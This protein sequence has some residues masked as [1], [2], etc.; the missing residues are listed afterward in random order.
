MAT[1]TVTKRTAALLA[2]VAVGLLLLGSGILKTGSILPPFEGL[3]AGV[4]SAWSSGNGLFSVA[5]K[6]PSPYT[7]ISQDIHNTILQNDGSSW[8]LLTVGPGQVRIETQEPSL[9]SDGLTQGKEVDYWVKNGTEYYEVKGQVNVYTVHVTVSA[10]ETGWLNN[11]YDFSGEQIWMQLLGYGW[12]QAYQVQE[13]SPIS[14]NPSTYGRAW[15][16]PLAVFIENYQ[17]NTYGSEHT[18]IDP[19]FS[20]RFITLYTAPRA[21]GTLDDLG[22]QNGGDPNSTLG[23]TAAP[24]SRMQPSAYFAFTLTDFGVTDSILGAKAPV[25]DYTLKVYTLQL[26]KYTFVNPDDTPWGQR[27]QPCNGLSCL[28]PNLNLWDL[29][30]LGAFGIV[31]VAVVVVIVLWW[32][33]P[34]RGGK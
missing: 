6:A 34:R 19:S 12:N 13:N 20:G 23:N 14:G 32:L 27:T 1:K 33:V 10:Q 22:L 2:V 26:G 11:E 7:W 5:T 31:L 18:S 28:I 9:S 15:E 24:D 17:M 25:A 4:N 29:F 21:Y 8:N 16:A 30:G 3:Q